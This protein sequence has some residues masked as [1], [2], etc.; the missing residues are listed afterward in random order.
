MKKFWIQ[1][2][3]C[4]KKEMFNWGFYKLT[5]SERPWSFLAWKY[6]G[7]KSC[8]DPVS[9]TSFELV[10]GKG[11]TTSKNLYKFITFRRPVAFLAA[12]NSVLITHP[13]QNRIGIYDAKDIKFISWLQHPDNRYGYHFKFPISFLLSNNGHFIILEKNQINILN[14]N[15]APCQKAILGTFLS[16]KLLQDEFVVTTQLEGGPW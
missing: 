6:P 9:D 2:N 5:T 16:I 3:V 10:G 4:L 13:E 8:F 14:K 1:K 7:C 15:F 12:F 11:K